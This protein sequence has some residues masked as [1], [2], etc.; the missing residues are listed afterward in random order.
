MKEK[1]K[2]TLNIEISNLTEAQAIALE[3]MF[4]QWTYL[5]NIGASRWT[6]FFADGDGNFRPHITVNG[7]EPQ[8]T[9]KINTFFGQDKNV[10]KTVQLPLP[11]RD[12]NKETEWRKEY[13][14]YMI[15]FDTIAWK[16]RDDQQ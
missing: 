1:D 13:E 8:F 15:D 2:K 12:N 9:D 7:S 4:R 14:F 16:L 6:A 11:K 10:W 3:D 5:G